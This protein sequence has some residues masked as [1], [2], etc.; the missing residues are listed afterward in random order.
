M[1]FRRRFCHAVLDFHEQQAM[2][3]TDSTTLDRL[4]LSIRTDGEDFP[5]FYPFLFEHRQNK[6][7]YRILY[8]VLIYTPKE[9]HCRIF[10]T[11]GSFFARQMVSKKRL[12]LGRRACSVDLHPKRIPHTSRPPRKTISFCQ[13]LSREY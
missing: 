9:A 6:F 3:P 12:F 13:H 4:R 5:R 7:F 8:L 10:V 1:F 2:L 11:G